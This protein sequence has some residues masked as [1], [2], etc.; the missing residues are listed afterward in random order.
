MVRLESLTY[1][2]VSP[3]GRADWG[4]RRAGWELELR[5]AASCRASWFRRRAT[6]CVDREAPFH[7][8]GLERLDRDCFQRTFLTELPW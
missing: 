5:F 7:R 2:M 4:A 3:I 8:P 1:V 6:F